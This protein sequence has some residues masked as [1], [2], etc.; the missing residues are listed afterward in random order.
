MA[1]E[2][3]ARLYVKTVA[4]KT[5]LSLAESFFNSVQRQLVSENFRLFAGSPGLTLKNLFTL[6]TVTDK[7]FPP[8]IC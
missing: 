3:E 4:T 5:Y 8:N 1:K 7:L 6:L 2:R